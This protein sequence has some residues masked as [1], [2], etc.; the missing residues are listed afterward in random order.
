M[1]SNQLSY[2]AARMV[3]FSKPAAKILLFFD[4]S[5]C[6]IQKIVFAN[7]TCNSLDD[8]QRYLFGVRLKVIAYD[9]YICSGDEGIGHLTGLAD[10][11]SNDQRQ[12]NSLAH[13]MDN[14]L[15]HRC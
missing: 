13:G 11:S 14:R 7:C 8:K 6:F 15:W 10:T 4:I 2:P 9:N 5:K 1:R 12:V 3:D